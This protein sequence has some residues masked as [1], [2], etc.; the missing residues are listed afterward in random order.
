M[1]WTIRSSFQVSKI[2]IT[3]SIFNTIDIT[4]LMLIKIDRTRSMLNKI[5]ITLST[6]SWLP[7]YKKRSK[8][9]WHFV[10]KRSRVFF[11]LPCPCRT[12]WILRRTI[13]WEFFFGV[14]FFLWASDGRNPE[15]SRG[16][17]LVFEFIFIKKKYFKI[18]CQKRFETSIHNRK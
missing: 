7:T 14:C 11:A 6:L 9:V 16:I 12:N 8:Q 3:Q 10:H 13:V 5:D 4:R 18:N 2:D 15:G 1:F 17:C